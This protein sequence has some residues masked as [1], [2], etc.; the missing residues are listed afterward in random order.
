MS[1]HIH[2]FYPLHY[3][4]A[5]YSVGAWV[6]ALVRDCIGF[7][8]YSHTA[9]GHPATDRLE[10]SSRIRKEQWLRHCGVDGNR[11]PMVRTGKS[12]R[13]HPWA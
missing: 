13:S 1:T 8:G 4:R 3:G 9:A 11:G 12:G 7:G 10:V 6:V 2:T 5:L